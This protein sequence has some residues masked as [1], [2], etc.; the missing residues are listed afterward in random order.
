MRN[1]DLALLNGRIITM[2]HRLPIS[3]ALA[4]V[5]DRL[6]QVG[7]EADVRASVGPGTEII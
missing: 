5:G 7:D 3:Q 2:D 1:A 4:V 6:L